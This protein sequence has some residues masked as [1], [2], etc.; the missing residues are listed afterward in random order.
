MEWE[1]KYDYI[2][3]MGWNSSVSTVTCHGLDGQGIECQ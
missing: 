2:L 3:Q 1:T